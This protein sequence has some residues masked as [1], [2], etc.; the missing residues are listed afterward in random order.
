MFIS[1]ASERV[2]EEKGTLHYD[3]GSSATMEDQERMSSRT[4]MRKTKQPLLDV[5]YLSGN[6]SDPFI[7]LF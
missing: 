4:T 5:V 3:A 1:H 7:E 6:C 2:R